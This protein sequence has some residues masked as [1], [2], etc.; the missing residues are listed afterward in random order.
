HVYPTLNFAEELVR[1]GHRVT[2]GTSRSY[3]AE[4]ERIGARLLAYPDEMA[5]NATFA[6]MGEVTTAKATLMGMRFVEQSLVLVDE[7]AAAF[8]DDRP[9]L[10]VADAMMFDAATVLARRWQVPAVVTHLHFAYDLN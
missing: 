1:R 9:A 10:I 8:E 6:G 3:A 7:L 5:E 4:V 2:Y